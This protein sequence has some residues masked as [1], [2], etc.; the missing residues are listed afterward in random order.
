M[1][2]GSGRATIREKGGV[3]RSLPFCWSACGIWM[4]AACTCSGPWPCRLVSQLIVGWWL[5][6]T[7]PETKW[8]VRKV[9]IVK[10]NFIKQALEFSEGRWRTGAMMCAAILTFPR[11]IN[12]E[13][14]ANEQFAPC[15]ET[16]G[17]CWLIVF[18]EVANGDFDRNV[19]R[20]VN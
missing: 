20:D 9:E 14:Q 8:F 3:F 12:G 10:Q 4:D 17:F 19:Q 2:V 6:S 16:F 11:L 5:P 1:V 7:E 13:L 18:V 15:S